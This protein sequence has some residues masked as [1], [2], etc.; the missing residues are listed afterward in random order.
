MDMDRCEAR[1]RKA[2]TR[3]ARL[4]RRALPIA[5]AIVFLGAA[6]LAAAEKAQG[7][8]PLDIYFVDTEGGAA[9]LIVT[10]AGESFLIDPGYPGDRD[11]PRI[12]QVAREAAKLTQI[13][14]FLSTHWHSDHVGGLIQLVKLIPIK[15]FYDRGSADKPLPDSVPA[16]MKAYREI[17]GGKSVALKPG[18]LIPL[19]KEGSPSPFEVKVLASSG[20]V[21]GEKAGAAQIRP[22]DKGHKSAPEDTSEN[23]RSVACLLRFGDFKLFLGADLTLNVEHKLACPENIPGPVDV[24]QV[25]HHGFA[26]SNHPALVQALKP[27]VA[28]LL[29]G[30]TKGG[31]AETLARLREVR[32]IDIYQMH[33]NLRTQE[34]DNAPEDFTLSAATE[35]ECK[36]GTMKLSVHP[37]GKSYSI[38]I[39][40]KGITRTY[41]VR[42]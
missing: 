13:D 22:C 11:P 15:R 7:E 29:N 3:R 8:K 1:L 35:K 28:I 26:I 4:S 16:E 32:G 10:P 40:S 20:A 39:P 2:A 21:L 41:E 30:P 25:D 33:R 36:G 9:T 27:R 31:D 38:S 37:S 17:T 23:A 18:D 19:S 24:F 34:D 14:H 12:A 42:A 6:S 5:F